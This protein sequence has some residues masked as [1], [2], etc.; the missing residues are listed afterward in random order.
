MSKWNGV[1]LFS[2]QNSR[3]LFGPSVD[4]EDLLQESN[5]TGK[6]APLKLSRWGIYHLEPKDESTPLNKKLL[7]M[8]FTDE[9]EGGGGGYYDSPPAA[10]E[11]RFAEDI[12]NWNSFI[13]S[14]GID[15]EIAIVVNQVSNFFGHPFG[16]GDLGGHVLPPSYVNETTELQRLED[17][18]VK[19][20][21]HRGAGRDNLNQGPMPDGGDP[22]DP[23]DQADFLFSI[24]QW[25]WQK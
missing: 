18:G 23:D 21:I 15:A 8:T 2:T 12:T 6:D 4:T 19:A 11:A 1:S 24:F 10:D 13:N 3:T 20:S 14:L 7:A 25:L 9:S 16:S 22:Q 5:E 17:L